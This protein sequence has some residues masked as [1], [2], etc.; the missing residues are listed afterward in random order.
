MQLKSL[1]RKRKSSEQHP[2]V[3]VLPGGEHT[4][5]KRTNTP[6]IQEDE[7]IPKT[8]EERQA[9]FDKHGYWYLPPPVERPRKEIRRFPRLPREI[10]SHSE[11]NELMEQGEGFVVNIRDDRKMLHRVTC[12]ALEVSST[13]KYQKLFFEDFEKVKDWLDQNYGQDGWEACGRCRY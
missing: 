2:I 8:N 9:Y 4:R 11:L 6:V 1:N 13:R 5:P 10:R 12:E 3:R 7:A